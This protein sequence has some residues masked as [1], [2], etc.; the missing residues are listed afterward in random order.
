MSRPKL[1]RSA[2]RIGATAL[3]AVG[4]LIVGVAVLSL[5]FLAGVHGD[6]GRGGVT[7]MALV[8]FLVLP[9]AV[10]YPSIQLLWL[11]PRPR[12][13]KRAPSAPA[14]VPPA[15]AKPAETK[16]SDPEPAP[17]TS[18]SEAPSGTSGAPA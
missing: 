4:L 5:A 15:E 8:T 7:L 6:F 17:S 3:L 11:G 1:A 12:A 14:P 10:L 18:A 16:A 2:L 13:V 9:Y